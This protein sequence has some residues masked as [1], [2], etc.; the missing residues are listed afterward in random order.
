MKVDCYLTPIAFERVKIDGRVAVVIDVLRSSTSI[1]RALFNGARGVIPVDG[2][3]EAV[4]I[5]LKLDPKTTLLAGER[6]G[7]KI[8]NF[9]LGNSPFEFSR[10]AVEDKLVLM[11]TTNGTPLFGRAA[12]ADLV[13][14]GTF[15]NMTVLVDRLVAESKDVVLVC[16]GREGSFSIED[17]LAA[18]MIVSKLIDRDIKIDCNDA[19]SAAQLLYRHHADTLA[20]S[21]AG[22]Q[23]GQHLLSLGFDNDLKLAAATDALPMLPELIDG[24]L[25]ISRNGAIESG[26]NP[27]VDSITKG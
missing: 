10:E 11:A 13:L 23:H 26:S 27:V 25:V 16:A 7:L 17:T 18:G 14:N 5:R 21:I 6:N 4:D 2:P 9:D 12:T 1:C 19:A 22:G 24:R 3:G 20:A 8:E 15:V